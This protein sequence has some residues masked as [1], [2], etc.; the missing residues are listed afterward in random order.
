MARKNKRGLEYFP[1][2]VDFFQ[3]LKIRKLVKY[4]GGGKAIA[5]Y[6]L[7]LCLIYR[8]GYYMMWDEELPFIISEQ[9]GF[10][11]AYIRE[12]VNSCLNIGLLD[13]T[14]FKSE[15]ILTSQGI[16]DRY[17]KICK[18]SKRNC[19]ISEFNLISSEEMPI[20]SEEMPISSEEMPISSEFMQQSKVKK[21]K[22]NTPLTPQGGNK[23]NF[24]NADSRRNSR[25]M[26]AKTMP[27]PGHGLLRRPDS[28][29]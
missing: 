8:D 9:T 2:D 11:E 18:L 17:A 25:C 6:A 7:L 23:Q 22:V 21:S 5:V 12:V 10:D 28:K 3:D 20:S 16:Q 24:S 27:A 26:Q 1:L 19:I 29:P 4:Q 15:R 13:K 14:L